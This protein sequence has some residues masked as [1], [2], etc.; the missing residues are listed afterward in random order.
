MTETGLGDE[1]NLGA[2][3]LRAPKGV[4]SANERTWE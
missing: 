4:P 3:A 1:V 2:V